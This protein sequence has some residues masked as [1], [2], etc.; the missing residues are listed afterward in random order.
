MATIALTV[1]KVGVGVASQSVGVLSEGIHSFLDL[2]SAGVA[3][4]TIRAAGKPADHDHPYGHGKIETLSSLL[5]SVLLVVAAAWIFWEGWLHWQN[6]EPI[7]HEGLAIATIFISMVVSYFM[8]RHNR[9]AADL[10]ES[11]AIHVNALHFLADVVA[12]L[13]VLVGLLLMRWTGWLW[14]DPLMAFGIA[15]YIAAISV[16]QVKRAIGELTDTQL[17]ASEL[18]EL[19]EI[20]KSGPEH[21]LEAHDLRSR[22]GGA[23]R[24]VDFHLVVCKNMTVSRSHEV[25]DDLEARIL[26]RFPGS[27]VTIHVEPCEYHQST[28]HEPCRHS[29]GRKS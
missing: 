11:S 21:V 12:S 15:A 27:S 28:C 7:Q 13:G 24:Y 1:F 16:K 20:L 23:T 9:G 8:Y 4:F 5:E 19:R 6:P 14:I 18:Q 22:K 17:P 29:G 10:T 3:F 26:T 2:L 25:C